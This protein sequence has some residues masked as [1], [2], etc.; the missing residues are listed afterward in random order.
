MNAPQRWKTLPRAACCAGG[1]LL[2]LTG[3]TSTHVSSTETVTTPGRDFGSPQE[4]VTTLH[5][6]VR[7]VP[8]TGL[9]LADAL[10]QRLTGYLTA[11]GMTLTPQAPDVIVTLAPV[12]SIFDESGEYF[13]LEGRATGSV[14]SAADG[15]QLSSQA[16]SVRGKRALGRD[17]ARLALVDAF[18]PELQ[19]WVTRAATPGSIPLAACEVRIGRPFFSWSANDPRYIQTFVKKIGAMPG[20]RRCELL[21]QNTDSRV[22]TFRIVYMKETYPEGILNAIIIANPDLKLKL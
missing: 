2:G 19:A 15:K 13:L 21:T 14:L 5:V 11:Q 4:L 22:C 20:V 6:A 1:L 3:C 10:G 8:P 16:F 7:T 18:L 17:A 12:E 9:P